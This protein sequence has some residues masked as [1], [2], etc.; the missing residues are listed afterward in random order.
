[1]PIKVVVGDGISEEIRWWEKGFHLADGPW[2]KDEYGSYFPAPPLKCGPKIYS[3]L[4]S[5]ERGQGITSP[6]PTP[7]GEEKGMSRILRSYQ[8]TVTWSMDNYRD[9]VNRQSPNMKKKLVLLH[10]PSI[11]NK[12]LTMNRINNK[13]FYHKYFSWRES[14]LVANFQFFKIVNISILQSNR[15]LDLDEDK[16]SKVSVTNPASFCLLPHLPP[17]TKNLLGTV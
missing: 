14:P 8:L 4:K 6:T 17:F 2:T 13:S 5:N 15:R 16:K 1:M 7:P 9:I 12:V 10:N 3:K 11:P